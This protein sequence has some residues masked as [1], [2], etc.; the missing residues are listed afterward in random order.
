MWL[1]AVAWLLLFAFIGIRMFA[2]SKISSDTRKQVAELEQ[3]QV[4]LPRDW[5]Q[6]AV[7]P[8]E[9]VVVFHQKFRSAME[10]IRNKHRLLLDGNDRRGGLLFK[11]K[12][13][14][15]TDVE[16]T[17]LPLL[18]AD[19]QPLIDET[20]RSVRL[21]GY[22]LEMD[23]NLMG[24]AMSFL[25]IQYFVKLMAIVAHE[26]ARSGDCIAAMETAELSL[27]M[28]KRPEQSYLIT[29]LITVA[30]IDIAATSLYDISTQCTDTQTLQRCLDMMTDLRESVFP[31]EIKHWY[32]DE[33][34]AL[35]YAA[36]YGYPVNLSPQSAAAFAKQQARLFSKKYYQWIVANVSSSDPKAQYA[37]AQ[38]DRF[39]DRAKSRSVFDK[40]TSPEVSGFAPGL[41]Y[42]LTGVD[43]VLIL[44]AS[45]GANM[46]IA[47]TRANVALARYDLTRLDIAHRLVESAS[48]ETTLTAYLSPIPI[49]PFTLSPFLFSKTLGKYYSIGP[50][51]KDDNT[52][53]PY[54]SVNEV[55]PT[56]DIW[57]EKPPTAKDK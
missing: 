8:P 42:V 44:Y 32:F 15:L 48:P 57:M 5:H 41:F 55:S 38:I 26:Q 31:G 23:L 47:S 40:L 4:S 54:D 56:G 53:I 1:G 13:P 46:Q 36:A 52:A 37:K 9:D 39:D 30:L 43:P 10:S 27:R 11:Y 16:R 45:T 18:M 34:V 33:L 14:V 28:A 20:S 49:D 50:N 51:L 22:V 29:H 35:R 7:L 21:P 3:T 17:S 19:L 2:M 24:Q 12:N 25:E 6:P